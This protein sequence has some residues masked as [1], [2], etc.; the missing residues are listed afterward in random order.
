MK[1]FAF[2]F[3]L[4]FLLIPSPTQSL[5]HG[6][7]A[8]LAADFI[9]AVVEAGRTTYSEQVVEHLAR[10]N[11]LTASE[12]WEQD[13]TLLLPAQFFSMS[14]K[15]SNS[16]GIGMK[17]RLLSLWPLNNNNAPRSKMKN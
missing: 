4:F 17:Y 15:I 9:H 8:G 7:P 1:F 5:E 6:V 16:R 14:S 11:S 3:A 10:Q 2:R 13:K 12:S